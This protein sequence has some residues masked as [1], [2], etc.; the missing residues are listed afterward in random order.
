MAACT[1]RVRAVRSL[2]RDV[3]EVDF[4]MVSPER[5]TFRAGQYVSLGC[6]NDASGA[7]VRRAY[8][9]ASS[10]KR[11]DG[12]TLVVKVNPVEALGAAE[13]PGSLFFRSLTPGHEVSFTGPMGFFVLDEQHP[14]DI[15]F[16]ATGTGLSPVLPMVE[17]LIAR[18]EPH[19]I[20]LYWGLRHNSDLFYLDELRAFEQRSARFELAVSLS[21]PNGPWDGLQGRIDGHVLTKLPALTRPVVYMVGNGAMIQ[22]LRAALETLGVDRKRQIRTEAYFSA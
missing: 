4:A 1:A 21:Q 5:F 14:G 15:V 9:I 3:L 2:T 19:R 8:S 18:D 6:G 17:E 11:T 12:F 20:M 10:T 13:G 16:A 22:Q 7:P